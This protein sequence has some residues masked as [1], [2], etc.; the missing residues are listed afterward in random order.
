[1]STT[2]LV[3]THGVTPL[4]TRCVQSWKMPSCACP[5][6]HSMVPDRSRAV[7][8]QVLT[9]FSA[10]GVDNELLL[11][12]ATSMPQN[13]GSW[14]ALKVAI[15]KLKASFTG[16]GNLHLQGYIKCPYSDTQ[17]LCKPSALRTDA[18]C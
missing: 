13:T 8:W 18:E 1:M 9:S 5:G 3:L 6:T 16:T 17:V 10:A 12:A 4:H 15:P 2:S 14:Q 7:Y 11:L